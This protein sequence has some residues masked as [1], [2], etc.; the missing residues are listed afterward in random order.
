MA[1]L[2]VMTYNLHGLHDDADAVVAVLRAAAPD[3]V[4]V[5]EPPRGPGGRARLSGLARAAGLEPAVV[6]GGARTTALL[7][8]TGLR[9]DRARAVRLSWRPG[10]TARGA[11]VA[12][13]AGVRVVA[14]HLGL[15]AAERARHVDRLLLLAATAPHHG[16]VLAGD[17][18]EQPG[19]PSWRRLGL[20][21]RDV[22][23]TSGPTYSTDDLR[24][25]IDAVLATGGLL[26]RGAR[27]VHDDAALRASD[28]LP[29]VVD[30]VLP[31]LTAPG[32]PQDAA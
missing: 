1:K 12:H 11:A 29:V 7:V 6:G 16:C 20:R 3:V 13:V 14:V 8:R 19:G 27:T 31:V 4:A 5:Q 21:L 9:V 22:T 32:A 26:A 28:H 17:L 2:R 24:W 15:D 18:N 23:A 10:R 25:R 30:L